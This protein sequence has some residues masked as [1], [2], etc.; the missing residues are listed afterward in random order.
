MNT[1]IYICIS[2]STISERCDVGAGSLRS[3]PALMRF[4]HILYECASN[5]LHTDKCCLSFLD[6]L[7]YGCLLG[8]IRTKMLAAR[9]SEANWVDPN[10]YP[11]Q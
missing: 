6:L 11:A 5:P 8:C 9:C 3:N 10:F 4:L 1:Y 7:H 2:A